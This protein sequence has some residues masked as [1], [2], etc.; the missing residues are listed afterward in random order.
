MKRSEMVDLITTEFNLV[1]GMAD[2]ILALIESKGML[3]PLAEKIENG[4]YVGSSSVLYPEWEKE[5]K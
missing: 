5:G 4:R 2:E 3:P 1:D